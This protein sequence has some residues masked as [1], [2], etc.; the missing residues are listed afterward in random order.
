MSSTQSTIDLRQAAGARV[1]EV[2]AALPVAA[3][4]C[5]VAGRITFFNERAAELWGRRPNLEDAAERYCGSQTLLTVDG[6]QV[7]HETSWTALTLQTG[8]TYER[9]DVVVLRPDGSRR[10]VLAS[11]S[12]MY[13]DAG[14]LAGAA[15]ILID[16]TDQMQSELRR[17][18]RD[19]DD[20]FENGAIGVHWID[21]DG[22]VVRANQAQLDLLGHS[23]EAFIGQPIR[24]FCVSPETFDDMLQRATAGETLRNREVRLLASDGSIRHVLMTCDAV[25]SAGA[26][27]NLRC[28]T[29]D[30]TE[31]KLAKMAL[32]A[33]E[34]NFR[35][36]FDSVGVG[37]VQVAKNGRFMRVND[38]YCEITGYSREDLLKMGPLDLDHPDDREADQERVARFVSGV[39][40]FYRAEKRY[41]RKDGNVTWVRVAANLLRDENPESLHSAAIVEDISER[42]LAEQALQDADRIKDEF[43]ATLAHE[44]R[45]PLAPMQTA[46]DVLRC[47]DAGQTDWCHGVLERQVKHLTQLVSD[48]LDI[49]RITSNKLEVHPQPIQLSDV[50]QAA[51]ESTRDILERCDQQL[52]IT[53]P[54]K[55]LCLNG[56]LVRLAQVFSNLLS[57]AAKFTEGPGTVR[58]T[59]EAVGDEIKV[60][61]ADT[62]IGM[63]KDDLVR[64]FDKFYQG[65]RRPVR[66]YGGLGIGLSLVRQ[67]VELHGGAI[68]AHSA[69][70][71]RGSEFVVRLPARTAA[72]LVTPSSAA[73]FA[74]SITARRVLVVDDNRDGAEAIARLLRVLGHEVVLAYDGLTALERAKDFE[75]GVVL[76]D[77]G[78][79]GVDGFQVCERMRASSWKQRPC[80][81]ALTGWG[82]DRD[83]ERTKNAGFDAHLVKPVDAPTL[84]KLLAESNV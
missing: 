47:R 67:L 21:G 29:V 54:S 44:L 4:T 78:M 37:A 8:T 14:I 77:L 27:Q 48:L 2:L 75:P 22:I 72:A 31:E 40:P 49:S 56:D 26:F 74:R 38:R 58:L 3:Y 55:Q 59:A 19:A 34:A 5:D 17:R 82:R 6:V 13:D 71:D 32:Q 35:G 41:I 20:F 83:L 45:N 43:I 64:A 12:P 7:P 66:S 9:R 60:T 68:E 84:V 28:F 10:T 63:P 80:I 65:S 76:L 46:I 30:V 57:N 39:D 79:P 15:T 1:R 25:F 42:K 16:I 52:I 69:G 18:E 51:V 24:R 61:V 50:I 33:S 53:M 23:S 81:V 11:V 36:F 70:V 62:G 73:G